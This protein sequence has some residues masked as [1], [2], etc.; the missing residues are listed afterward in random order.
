MVGVW[1]EGEL[2]YLLSMLLELHE[3]GVAGLQH[4][5]LDYSPSYRKAT[6]TF[7]RLTIAIGQKMTAIGEGRNPS[8]QS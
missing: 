6:H 3:L 8:N 1:T 5:L 7:I 4:Y 2:T